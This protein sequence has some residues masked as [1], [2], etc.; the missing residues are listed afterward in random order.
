MAQSAREAVLRRIRAAL[1]RDRLPEGVPEALAAGMGRPARH[2]RPAA[3]FP[4]ALEAAGCTWTRVPTRVE[5][6]AALDR[7][8]RDNAIQQVVALP[9]LPRGFWPD[10]AD[11]GATVAP[12]GSLAVGW[13]VLGVAETGSLL[14]HGATPGEAAG[15][16]LAEHLALIL[17]ASAVVPGLE[18]AWDR[19]RRERPLPWAVSFITGPSRTA[20]V[21]QTLQIGAH[22]PRRVHVLLLEDAGL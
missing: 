9:S 14:V 11:P 20:D 22:G 4:A 6:R 17:D 15:W 19:L 2:C 16:V 5:A 18:H 13:A 8:R 1:G 7:Y 21:E 12:Q 3:D 10:A